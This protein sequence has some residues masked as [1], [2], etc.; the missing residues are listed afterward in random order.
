MSWPS[1]ADFKFDFGGWTAAD[2][3][4][5]LR[6]YK[7]CPPQLPRE[8][9]AELQAETVKLR[10]A[11]AK[12][13]LVANALKLWDDGVRSR[14]KLATVEQTDIERL[15][16]VGTL[17]Q[18][19]SLYGPVM[20]ECTVPSPFCDLQGEFTSQELFDLLSAVKES[21]D[22]QEAF[23]RTKKLEMDEPVSDSALSCE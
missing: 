22:S 1:H 20:Q 23:C 15:G 13:G 12:L 8:T 16:L 9:S 11:L 7:R 19:E 21:R 5:A 10:A 6:A 3:A 18:Y 2:Y 14:H 17:A 4:V